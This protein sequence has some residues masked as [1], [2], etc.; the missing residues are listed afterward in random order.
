M[1]LG[2][3]YLGTRPH[4]GVFLYIPHLNDVWR[5]TGKKILIVFISWTFWQFWA[6]TATLAEMTLL[7]MRV[8]F[9][10]QLDTI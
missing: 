5:Q 3:I 2:G 4:R 9:N 7:L 10:C 1:L 6:K 8:N